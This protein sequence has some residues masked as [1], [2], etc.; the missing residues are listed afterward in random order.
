ML[1][2]SALRGRAAPL[3]AALTLV[4]L[5]ALGSV[6][7]ALASNPTILPVEPHGGIGLTA[8]DLPLPVEPDGGIGTSADDLP[9]PVE[10]DGGIG[11]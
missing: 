9:L 2:P 8:D 1:S 6:A 7:V 11:N 3:V 10:P 4:L 5:L